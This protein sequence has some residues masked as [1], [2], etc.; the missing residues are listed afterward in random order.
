MSD[1]ETKPQ[2]EEVSVACGRDGRRGRGGRGGQ[3]R[4]GGGRRG[5]EEVAA[6]GGLSS[7]DLL[8]GLGSN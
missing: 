5:R 3:R 2:M 4:A 6:E 1:D 7:Q 8:Q